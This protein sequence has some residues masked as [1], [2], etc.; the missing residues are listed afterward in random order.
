MYDFG[1]LL[2]KLRDDKNV[3]MDKMIE[4]IKKTYNISIAKSTISKWENNKA[5]PTLENA[6]ILSSYFNVS[7]DYLLGL[8][9]E[10]GEENLER[11]TKFVESSIDL[12][13]KHFLDS[14]LI[15]DIDNMDSDTE[16][17]ILSLVKRELKK[18]K[19]EDK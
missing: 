8:T 13:L 9:N 4:D 18:I 5:E 6:R 7:I 12:L 14:G 19:E 11:K 16:D 3:S 10:K 1:R 2:K 17:M 15:T